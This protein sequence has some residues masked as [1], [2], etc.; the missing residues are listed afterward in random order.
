M[1][2]VCC[3][4]RS[5]L[6]G[7]A[8]NPNVTSVK[9]DISSNDLSG[10]GAEQMLTVVGRVSCLQHLNISECGLEQNMSHIISAVTHNRNIAHLVLGRN[11]SGKAA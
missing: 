7:L 3:V 11:F 8:V 1:C 6:E 5:M 9:L 2:T 4:S 10:A